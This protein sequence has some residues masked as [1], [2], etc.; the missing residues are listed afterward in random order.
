MG[1]DGNKFQAV[2]FRAVAGICLQHDLVRASELI[3]IIHLCAAE[4]HLQRG[5]NIGELDAEALD[6]LAIHMILVARGIGLEI[7]ANGRELRTAVRLSYDLRCQISQLF[8]RES[9]IVLHL[10]RPSAL[11]AETR[12][13]RRAEG[14]DLR[15]RM[16]SCDLLI[17]SGK[18]RGETFVPAGACLPVFQPDEKIRRACRG[19]RH[20]GIDAGER[21]R[22]LGDR[23]DDLDRLVHGG[24]FRH[25]DRSD[26]HALVFI[27]YEGRRDELVEK[28]HES[29]DDHKEADRILQM[30]NHPADLARV[31][32]AHR[33]K[34]AVES[35]KEAADHALRDGGILRLEEHPAKRRCQSQCDQSGDRY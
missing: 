32:I 10:H 8:I 18:D 25:R 4:I 31:R 15:L 19:I 22:L 34:S 12:Q 17:E 2:R 11:H 14:H 9:R 28:P 5:E 7:A 16:R 6:L 21:L 30:G 1:S 20:D 33:I 3:E 13:G 24:A 27:R 35:G 29:C 23:I 26:E